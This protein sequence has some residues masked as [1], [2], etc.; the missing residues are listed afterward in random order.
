M[1]ISRGEAGSDWSEIR[2][3]DIAT[4]K[5]LPDRIKWVKF[6]GAAWW[7][8]GFFYSGYDKPAA[9]KELTA[10]NEF[11]KVFYHK[12]GDPQEKDALVYEDK[13]HPLRY[14][15]AGVSEDEKY[16]LPDRQRGH[17]RDRSSTGKDL[18]K[19][20]RA[21]R[22][23][24][25]G[26][27][28]RQR[29][30][31]TTSATSSSSRPTSTRPTAKVVLIDPRKTRPRRTGRRSSPRSPRSWAAPATAGGQL[32]CT[33]L[34]DANTKVYQHGLD[35]TLV[36][37]I[38]L[39][40]LGTAGGFGGWR[41]D[42]IVFYTFT[43]FTYPSTIYQV[44]HRLRR[45]RGLPQARGQVRSR[46]TTRP[47]RSST[48]S[49]DGTK[50]P[51]FIVH[52]KGLALDGNESLLPDGLRRLQHQHPAR[53]QPAATSPCSRTAVVFAEP[54][55]RGGGEYGETWHKA[56]M[57]DKKQNVFDDF[58]AAAEYLIA[59]KYTSK[60]KLAIEG[61]SNGG[62]LVGRGHDPAARPVQGGPAR[63]R[64][65]GHAPLPQVHGRLGL[66]GRVRLERQRRPTSSG[67]TPT[68]R[69]TTSRPASAYPATLVTTADHDDRVVPAHSFKFVATLQEKHKRAPTPSS[70]GSRRAPAT[71]RAT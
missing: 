14:F 63:G 25:Q 37:E 38:E 35:G 60:D 12:L 39:P 43:S 20:G 69:S 2:V 27:R 1:A 40:A 16:A 61:G 65:H 29:A 13:D 22:A 52:K 53:L 19:Q 32:F 17:V 67:S 55:L 36:R 34:K 30:S 28:L 58:I 6:S 15:G 68:R 71:A 62:L 48:P 46:R 5:E 50:V 47:S 33:Y 49:K 31:S 24:D 51:M 59:E 42:K 66:G 41:D 4:K 23:A 45:L 21:L 57:L 10:K 3:M 26:L 11:Q 44:R 56:G 8:D 9:G 18:A 7:K 54:N 70:S 64:R